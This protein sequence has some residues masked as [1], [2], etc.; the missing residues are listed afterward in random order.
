VP[1]NSRAG[2]YGGVVVALV[3]GFYL[4]RL[5]GAEN[6][7]LLHTEHLISAIEDR[8][9]SRVDN[10]IDASY[11]DDWGFDRASLL[12]RL[13]MARQAAGNLQIEAQETEA[14]VQ[15]DEAKWSAKVVVHGDG[16]FAPMITDRINSLED[17]FQ[18]AWHKGSWKPWDWRLTRVG[19]PG[20]QLP[21]ELR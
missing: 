2:F 9:W 13:R 21:D 3:L 12:E 11:R 20:L 8:N 5:W 1:K 14:S 19:N 7:V 10:F 15:N 16:E 18:L 4:L 6:Q 17:R